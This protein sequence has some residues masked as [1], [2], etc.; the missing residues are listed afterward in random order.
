[1]DID[2]IDIVDNVDII[3]IVDTVEAIWNNARLCNNQSKKCEE[4]THQISIMALRDASA[5]KKLIL[6][7]LLVYK[8]KCGTICQIKPNL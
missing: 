8:H 2:I 1:M 4:P 7:L 3:D 5:S 6:L